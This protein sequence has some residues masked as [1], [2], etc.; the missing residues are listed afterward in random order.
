MFLAPHTRYIICS[1]P[2]L[3]TAQGKGACA[4]LA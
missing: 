3:P 4:L 2:S 1:Y